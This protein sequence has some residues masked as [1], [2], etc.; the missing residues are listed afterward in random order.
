[1]P[2]L[3][4]AEPA[5]HV[6]VL[7][8]AT[9]DLARRKLLPGLLHLSQAG[10]MPDF[11]VVGT[12]LEDLGDDAFRDLA[13]EAC[14][15]FA[16]HRVSPGELGGFTKRLTFVGHRAGADGLAEAVARAQRSLGGAPRRLH[17][18]S[19]PPAA[20]PAVVRVLGEAG[21]AERAR[22]VMEKPYGTDLAS[23]RELNA[24]VH[25]IFDERQVFRISGN[26]PPTG[27]R[28]PRLPARSGPDC[29]AACPRLR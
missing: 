12:S 4:P 16:R 1:M 29:R 2:P 23:A 25:E 17:Y 8:G 20:A 18:L 14:E 3:S 6:I 7:F 11:R 21:L 13:R 26:H 19:V 5:P 24:M 27:P 15:A 9:G 22:V 28:G 10:L